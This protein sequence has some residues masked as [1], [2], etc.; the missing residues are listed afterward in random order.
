MKAMNMVTELRTESREYELL[1]ADLSGKNYK[2]SIEKLKYALE[3]I[4]KERESYRRR[5]SISILSISD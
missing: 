2:M 4:R 1:S 3:D 5:W